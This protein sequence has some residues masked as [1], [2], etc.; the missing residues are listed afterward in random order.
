[1]AGERVCINVNNEAMRIDA[2]QK[3]AA[4]GVQPGQVEFY[5]HPTNDAW[6]RDHGPAFLV[7][8]RDIQ[9]KIIVDW[10]YNAWGNKYPPFD[11]DDVIPTLIAKQYGIPVY[12]PGIIMEG[13]QWILTGPEPL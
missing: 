1:M 5:I 3:L 9:K 7:N 4:A 10:N 2:E 12:Y 8:P 13:G 6:C 11:L